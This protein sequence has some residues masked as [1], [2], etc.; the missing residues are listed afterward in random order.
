MKMR[1][2]TLKPARGSKPTPLSATV[3]VTAPGSACALMRTCAS[4]RSAVN[5][6]ALPIKLVITA[7]SSVSSGGSGVSSVKTAATHR[8]RRCTERIDATGDDVPSA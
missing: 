8:P 1:L 7:R 4:V 5:F 2:N 3:T 6:S